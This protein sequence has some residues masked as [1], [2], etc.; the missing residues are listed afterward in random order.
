MSTTTK[1]QIEATIASRVSVRREIALPFPVPP[2]GFCGVFS[3]SVTF[4]DYMGRTSTAGPLT[5]VTAKNS[6]TRTPSASAMAIERW[7]RLFFCASVRTIPTGLRLSSM[8]S[9]CAPYPN[10]GAMARTTTSSNSV[11]NNANR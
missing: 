5:K 10:I 1:P 11:A 6:T 9:P 2:S 8:R 7:R 3:I 4:E